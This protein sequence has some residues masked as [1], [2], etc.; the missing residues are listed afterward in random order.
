MLTSQQS[1]V[2]T[3]RPLVFATFILCTKDV[4]NSYTP[5]AIADQIGLL[6]GAE[7]LNTTFNQ[8]SGYLSVQGTGATGLK[9]KNLHYWFVESTGNPSED[10]IAFWTNGGPGNG[11]GGSVGSWGV[12]I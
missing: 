11:Y 5:D 8:F 9:S 10:P 2:A 6:P 3:M 12:L 7:L 1:P 4:V